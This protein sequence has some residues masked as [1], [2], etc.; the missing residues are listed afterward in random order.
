MKINNSIC[1]RKISKLKDDGIKINLK[2]A[3]D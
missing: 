3:V 2:K 1:N